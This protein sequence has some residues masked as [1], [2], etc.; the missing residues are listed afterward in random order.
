MDK[1]LVEILQET[2]GNRAL[3]VMRDA[4][5]FDYNK[6]IK[7]VKFKDSFTA[8]SLKNLYGIDV[9]EMI[10]AVMFRTGIH[11]KIAEYTDG[12]VRLC[13]CSMS[14]LARIVTKT[15]FNEYR[16]DGF[17]EVYVIAQAKADTLTRLR[18]RIDGLNGRHID[19]RYISTSPYR[20]VKRDSARKGN[21]VFS[22]YEDDLDKSGYPV[23]LKREV[24]EMKA[25]KLKTERDADAYK[26]MTNT[27]DMIYKARK[28]IEA[29]QIEL[30]KKLAT[31]TTYAEVSVISNNVCVI[32]NCLCDLTDILEDDKNKRFSSPK[33]FN[34]S[35]AYIYT[36]L[37]RI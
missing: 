34:D 7:A 32:R 4:F 24:L 36:R 23:G 2:K 9:K 6:P 29:K 15:D 26:A 31:A 33:S 35:I 5:G 12:V 16:K 13:D 21:D 37:D 3:Q 27:Q 18:L 14:P 10:V 8:T 25:R 22:C 17:F 20:A 28:A 11:F 30:A 1:L 19:E